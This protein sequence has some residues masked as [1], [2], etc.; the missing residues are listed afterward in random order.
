M[1]KEGKTSYLELAR[2][3]AAGYEGKAVK[4]EYQSKYGKRYDKDEAMQV[5]RALASVIERRKRR[6]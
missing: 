5:G 1:A 3:I 4:P 6:M 2:K